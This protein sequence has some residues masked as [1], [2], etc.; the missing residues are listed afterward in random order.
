[1]TVAGSPVRVLTVP[2][3][4][5]QA[6]QVARPLT[7]VD[8]ALSNIQV[9]LLI[10]SAVGVALAAGLGFLVARAALR[11]VH[12]LDAAVRDVSLTRD[13]TR[14]IDVSG[15][16][17]VAR[18]ASSFNAMLGALDEAQRAQRRL[19][20]DGSHELRTPLTSLRTNV[21]VLLRGQLGDDDR[22]RLARDVDGQI[23]ELSNLIGSMME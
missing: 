5:G 1:V 11:P 22:Q 19:A 3:T 10:V 14:R 15:T 16:D 13:L 6:L 7:E 8:D 2:W 17:E 18:L 23:V 4:P 21:E 20:A 12:A 9:I